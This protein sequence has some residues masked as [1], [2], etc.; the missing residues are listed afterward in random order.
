[1]D[2]AEY[3]IGYP[4]LPSD[5]VQYQPR[6]RP[7]PVSSCRHSNLGLSI[8]KTGKWTCRRSDHRPA[9]QQFPSSVFIYGCMI[10]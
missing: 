7:K 5:P 1:M 6:R 8:S 2:M 4:V 3:V 10:R 9:A